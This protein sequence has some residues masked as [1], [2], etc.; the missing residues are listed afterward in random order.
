MSTGVYQ[1]IYLF[2]AFA[3]H[4]R[5]QIAE[6]LTLAALRILVF[7]SGFWLKIM[8]QATKVKKNILQ[9]RNIIE[10]ICM[11]VSALSAAG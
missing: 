11:A 10:M 7:G 3:G 2:M 9:I 4:M 5:T 6:I 1:Y 8:A